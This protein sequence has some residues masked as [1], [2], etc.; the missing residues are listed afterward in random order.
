MRNL[1]SM[2]LEGRGFLDGSGLDNWFPSF[3]MFE[4][5]F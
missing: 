3:D 1:D 2:T 5:G 4:A